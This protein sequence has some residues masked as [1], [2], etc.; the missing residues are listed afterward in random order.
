MGGHSPSE[1]PAPP[2]APRL[3]RLLLLRLRVLLLLQLSD[4]RR[5]ALE[6]LLQLFDLP[7]QLLH[8][9]GGRDVHRPQGVWA[10]RSAVAFAS[11]AALMVFCSAPMKVSFW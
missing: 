9:A 6:D 3:V 10:A 4:L 11:S 5:Q 1:R 7:L 2:A 8:V